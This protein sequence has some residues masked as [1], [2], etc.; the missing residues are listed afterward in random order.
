MK[1][2]SLISCGSVEVMFGRLLDICG[3]CVSE[4]YWLH[5]CLWHKI[6]YLQHF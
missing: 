2:F 4:L 6:N 1:A 3:V 5:I